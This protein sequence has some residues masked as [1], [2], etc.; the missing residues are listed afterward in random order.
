L[1]GDAVEWVEEAW[2]NG[3]RVDFIGYQSHGGPL[4]VEVKSTSL[5]RRGVAFFPAS[6]SKRVLR[7]IESLYVAAYNTGAKAI[8]VIT[9]LRGDAELLRLNRS[10]DNIL[11]TRLAGFAKTGAMDVLAYKV[12]AVYNDNSILVTYS[13]LL[14]V[15]LLNSIN[16]RE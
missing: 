7:Q 14:Q 11:A 12:Q 9:V 8:L 5:V 2:I 4:L 1:L 6:P 15:D 3:T 16:R 13:G 10:I